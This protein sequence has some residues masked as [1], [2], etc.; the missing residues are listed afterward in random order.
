[1]GAKGQLLLFV[2]GT[3]GTGKVQQLSEHKISALNFVKQC[4]LYWD[5]TLIFTA[6]TGCADPLFG[7]I[8]L[9]SATYLNSKMKFLMI[10]YGFRSKSECKL[11]MEYPFQSQIR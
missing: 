9:H 1:M 7:E 5:E 6:I 4:V 3:A 11:L 8:A 2:A 10:C